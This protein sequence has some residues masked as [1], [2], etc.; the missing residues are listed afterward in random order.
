MFT[1]PV[2]TTNL[3]KRLQALATELFGRPF[4][5][6]AADA[7]E[8]KAGSTALG[9][10]YLIVRRGSVVVAA[11]GHQRVN[12]EHATADAARAQV[13]DLLRTTEG[14]HAVRLAIADLLHGLT[15]R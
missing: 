15:G 1:T 12:T 3:V 8:L 2:T 7:D 6:V 5:Q 9:T 13:V 14:P 11:I 4:N 10:T